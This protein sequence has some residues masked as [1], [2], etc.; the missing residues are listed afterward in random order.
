MTTRTNSWLRW[1]I[2]L[3]GA[4]GAALVLAVRAGTGRGVLARLR[5]FPSRRH[6]DHHALT[7]PSDPLDE[8]NWESFPASD[9]PAISPRSS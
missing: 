5:G 6:A 2:P 1:A 7:P 9:P 3:A 4:L 8:A